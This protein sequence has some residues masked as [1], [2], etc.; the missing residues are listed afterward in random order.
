MAVSQRTHPCSLHVLLLSVQ[1]SC[2]FCEIKFIQKRRPESQPCH[3]ESEILERK[4]LHEEH[5]VSCKGKLKPP[6]F[7]SVE[8]RS[9][10]AGAGGMVPRGKHLCFFLCALIT[11]NTKICI[12]RRS[13]FC[14]CFGVHRFGYCAFCLN[15]QGSSFSPS[16]FYLRSPL[17]FAEMWVPPLEGLSLVK[18]LLFCP[19]TILCK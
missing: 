14:V 2:I 17:S 16:C 15:M 12:Q 7:C 19:K 11:P 8:R 4:M 3:Q 9:S 1:W 10:L 13:P 5:L 18:K 6:P